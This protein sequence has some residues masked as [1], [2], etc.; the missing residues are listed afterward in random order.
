LLFHNIEKGRIITGLLNYILKRLLFI[1]VVLFVIVSLN[2]LIFQ[3]FCPINPVD[4]MTTPRF[5]ERTR[6]I[7]THMFGLD[8]PIEVRYAKYILN[9]LT[10]NLGVSFLSRRPVIEDVM[11]YLP[12][13]ILL[14]GLATALQIVIGIPLGVRSASGRGSKLDAL[15]TTMGLVSFATPAFLFQLISRLTFSH[16]LGWFPFGLMTSVPPPSDPLAYALDVF[17]HLVLP[18]F[19]L[20]AIN[21]GYWSLYARNVTLDALTEDYITTARGKGVS[22]RDVTYKYAFR[23]SL[24]PIVT[25]VTLSIPTIVTGAVMT[26]YIFNWPGIGWWLLDSMT[27][28]DYPAV[29]G[30][31]FIFSVLTLLANFFTDILYAILDPRIRVG[32]VQK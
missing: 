19:G 27:S 2:F 30:L 1:F 16:W 10:L 31:L 6:Q 26:E 13:T 18:V 32:A 24:P 12:N 14:L 25:L 3:V 7:L 23:A 28:G 5:T 17:Y 29:Q 15:I 22:E 4:V 21:F 20:V 8:Q 11:T 9:M